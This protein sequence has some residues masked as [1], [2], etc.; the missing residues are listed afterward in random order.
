M[1]AVPYLAV[2][3]VTDNTG[4]LKI[5]SQVES[6][7][8]DRDRMQRCL[9]EPL[10]WQ[11]HGRLPCEDSGN[12][13]WPDLGTT[14]TSLGWPLFPLQ[15]AVFLQR[16]HYVVKIEGKRLAPL[17]EILE[18]GKLPAPLPPIGPLVEVLPPLPQTEE[19][20]ITDDIRLLPCAAV[21]G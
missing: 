12:G 17:L 3:L 11:H 15:L 10:I 8:Q 6:Q 7:P 9:F 13:C 5:A 18:S 4:V 16:A 19:R 14:S 21:G 20:V 1:P 2:R